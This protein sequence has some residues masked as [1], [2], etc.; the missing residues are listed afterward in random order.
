M[1]NIISELQDR[2]E[3][4]QSLLLENNITAALI[5]KPRNLYYYTN[6]SQP[7]NLWIPVEGEPILFTRRVHEL[8]REQTTIKHVE[9]ATSLKQIINYLAELNMFPKANETIGV[10]LDFIPFNI[11]KKIEEVFNKNKLVSLTPIIA[12]QRFVKSEREIQ[13]IRESAKLWKSS[14]EAILKRVKAGMREYEV[15]SIFEAETRKNGGDGFVWFHRWDAILPGGGIVTS[16]ENTW[17]I[18]GHAMTVTGVGLNNGLPWGAS[19]K[20][21]KNNELMVVDYGV[22]K[23]SYH[24]DMA[25]TYVIGR[26]SDAQRD[27]WKKLVELHLKVID[28]IAPG[29]TGKEIY[30]AAIQIAKRMNLE[31]NFMGIGKNRGEYIGHSIGLEIDELPVIGPTATTPLPESGIITIEPK[32]MVPGIG[33]VMVEDDILI[34]NDGYEIIEDIGYELYEL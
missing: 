31:D 4:L 19:N 5:Q 15:S 23:N 1:T 29:K 22:T 9:E 24:S 16:G 13:Y 33:S 34:T 3:K 17:V 21:L 32:F 28:Q 18:S 7:S 8:T 2:I 25:R 12:E 10:E 11:I 30:D 26:A 27:L 20:I 14:H 6:T